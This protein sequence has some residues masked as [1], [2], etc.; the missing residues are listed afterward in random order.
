MFRTTTPV[1]IIIHQKRSCLTREVYN[2]YI[3]TTGVLGLKF[4][5]DDVPPQ[6]GATILAT[7]KGISYSI[8]G[9]FP[10]R[11]PIFHM[12]NTQSLPSPCERDPVASAGLG[13]RSRNQ[14]LQQGLHVRNPSLGWRS[15]RQCHCS[16]NIATDSPT[17]WVSARE[18]ASAPVWLEADVASTPQDCLSS[19]EER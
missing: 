3:T 2:P 6:P 10:L 18:A 11:D 17:M 1:A 14:A 15:G 8:R 16:V 12:I 4:I 5:T 13:R 9:T 7:Y 19:P